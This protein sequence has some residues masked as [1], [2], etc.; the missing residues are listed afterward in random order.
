MVTFFGGAIDVGGDAHKN[1]SG[2]IGGGDA[3]KDV[4]KL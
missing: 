2:A 1:V 4:F 3:Y